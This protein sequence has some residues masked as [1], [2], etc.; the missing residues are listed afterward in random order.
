MNKNLFEQGKDGFRKI[1]NDIKGGTVKPVED[2]DLV[3]IVVSGKAGVGKSTLINGVFGKDFAETGI[4]APVTQN[5]EAYTKPDLPICIYDVRGLE[6]NQKTQKKILSDLRGLIKAGLKT[7]TTDDNIHLMWYCVSSSGARLEPAEIAFINELAE[8]IDVIVVLTKSY[9]DDQT[10]ELMDYIEGLQ[11]SGELRSRA[12]AP[13]LAQ[14]LQV[15]PT[16]IKE[17]FGLTELS[18]LSFELLPDAQQRAFAS[19]QKISLGQRKKASY[20]AISLAGATAAAIGAIPFPV[21]DALLL[22][23]LQA[24]M[25]VKISNIYGVDFAENDFPKLVAL[26]A[27]LLAPAAG[28]AAVTSLVKLI[29][30][31]GSVI[32]GAVASTLTVGL[33]TSYMLALEKGMAENKSIDVLSPEFAKTLAP[34]LKEYLEK[35]NKAT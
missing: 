22:V 3:K 6:L 15:N 20:S 4:G 26:L 24:G 1:S 5:L 10:R 31:V 21:A 18:D 32:S 28:K 34:I 8:M 7:E 2:K 12:V 16:Q 14:D 35:K 27:P 33:G 30:G 25:F 23:P 11:A 17:S 29:P 13:V 9:S 19:V